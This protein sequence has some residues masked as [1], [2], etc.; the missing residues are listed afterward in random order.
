MGENKIDIFNYGSLGIENALNTKI[1][2]LTG[3]NSGQMKSLSDIILDVPSTETI[4]AY[5]SWA[6]EIQGKQEN[7]SAAYR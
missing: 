3:K 6:Q 7:V 1:I 2:S 4:W 5:R